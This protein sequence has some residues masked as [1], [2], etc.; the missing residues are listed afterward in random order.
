[1]P[2]ASGES[3][4]VGS[5]PAVQNAVVDALSH[6]GIRHLDMPAIPRT[7]M[8]RH[9]FF[10]PLEIPLRWRAMKFGIGFANILH[11]T[12]AEGAVEFGQSAEAAGFDSVWTVEHGGVPRR[13][14][15][16]VPL[17]SDRPNA[18]DPRL[19]SLP[20]P[21]IWL[22]WVASATTKLRLGTGILILPQRNPVVLA[23]SLGTLDSMSGGRVTLGVGVGWLKEEFEALGIPWERRGQRTDDY[24]GAMRALW[25]GD[26]ASFDSEH[27]SFSGV[28]VNPKPANG[29]VPIV[30]GGHSKAAARRAGRLGDG[31]WPGPR[32]G[33]SIAELIDVMRQEAAAAGRS[34]ENIEITV[35]LPNTPMDDPAAL[36]QEIDALGAHRLIV[37]SFLFFNDTAESMSAFGAQLQAAAQ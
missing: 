28:S 20:D 16:G 11:W 15:L 29:R 21:L 32:E 3:G 5:T 37:P 9:L 24:I 2:K 35:G 12:S 8:G 18:D 10:R 26:S 23:K 6:L 19:S 14:C 30:I 25:D 22:S 33:V 31:F 4:T 1:M 34:P 7:G 13:L 27:A 17:R 36:V